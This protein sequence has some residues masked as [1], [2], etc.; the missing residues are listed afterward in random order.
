MVIQSLARPLPASHVDLLDRP[1]PTVLTTEM[2]DGRLQSTV[3][4]CNRDG[5]NILLNTMLEFQKARNLCA[6][7]RATV[8]VVDP[9]PEARW[10][11]VRGVVA[12]QAG[13]GSEHLNELASLYAG[14]SRYFGEVV[15]AE[16]AAFEHPIAIRLTPTSVQ[17]GPQLFMDRGAR[18]PPAVVMPVVPRTC[19]EEPRIPESHH[20]LL[21]APVLAALSTR[22]PDG[23]ASTHPVWCS[24]GGND[25]LVNTTRQRRKGRNLAADPRATVLV[26]DPH[27]SNIWIEIRGDVELIEDGALEHLDRLTR[28]YTG[29]PRYYGGIY[30]IEQRAR[31]TR[32][33]A[34]IHPRRINCDAIHK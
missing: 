10:I 23:G 11:E 1:L 6:R 8:L 20:E 25:V 26:V 30:P 24:R 14:K 22:M 4:W 31:E 12:I 28:Q 5:N 3:V 19:A 2:P 32:V 9:G 29:H 21:D 33:I 15:P 13:D 18:P 16:F 17:T 7:P 34:R 27:D